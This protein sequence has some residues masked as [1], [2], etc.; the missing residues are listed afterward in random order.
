MRRETPSDKRVM[1]DS[2][3]AEFFGISVK[4]LQRRLARP[5]AGEINPN[6]AHPRTIGGRRLWLREDV[7]KLVGIK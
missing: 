1:F 4:T 3:V 6:M 7:E 5:A 2:E